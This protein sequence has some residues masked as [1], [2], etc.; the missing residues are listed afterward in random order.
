VVVGP[1]DVF[2]SEWLDLASERQTATFLKTLGRAMSQAPDPRLPVRLAEL[3]RSFESLPPGRKVTAAALDSAWRLTE[4]G[5]C[6]TFLEVRAVPTG[7]PSPE[8]DP[9]PPMRAAA[10]EGAVETLVLPVRGLN[11]PFADVPLREGDS[12]IVERSRAQYVSVLGLVRSPGNYPYPPDV[13]Y[14][15]A[16]AV[17]FA[18]GLDLVADPRYV[19]LYRLRPDGQ[20]AS[21]TIQLVDP[22]RKQVLTEALALP[23]RPGDI[24]SVEQTPRTRTNL[25]FDRVF[26]ISLGLYLNPDTAWNNR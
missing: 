20:V 5:S 17:G 24:V 4:D 10:D 16:Q 14:N 26:R 7:S 21:V 25:F 2:I 23:V 9:A 11:I 18:G 15:L 8:L 12:V 1:G 19:C 22:K 3:A 6:V 13:Q